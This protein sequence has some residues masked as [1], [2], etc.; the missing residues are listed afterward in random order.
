MLLEYHDGEMSEIQHLSSY[1]E[2]RFLLEK[3]AES[4]CELHHSSGL[5]LQP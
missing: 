1:G 4:L 2:V 3:R 5:R